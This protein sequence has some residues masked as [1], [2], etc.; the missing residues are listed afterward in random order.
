MDEV[1]EQLI[2]VYYEERQRLHEGAQARKAEAIDAILGGGAQQT[3]EASR[4]LGHPVHAWQTGFVSWTAADTH[5]RPDAAH[6]IA[7]AAAEALGT[8]RPLT[9]AAGSR[10]LWFWTATDNCPDLAAL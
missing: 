10:D 5:G 9:M 7:S 3:S 2:T 4:A 6:T 1:I 8:S